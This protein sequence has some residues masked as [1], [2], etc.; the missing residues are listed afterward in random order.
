MRR[1]TQERVA[2]SKGDHAE[3]RRDAREV[4]V[5][6][7]VVLRVELVDGD[8]V[9]IF[10]HQLDALRRR[11]K[12]FVDLPI[13]GEVVRLGQAHV[14]LTNPQVRGDGRWQCDAGRRNTGLSTNLR[15]AG[16]RST[17]P[18]GTG[19]HDGR[20]VLASGSLS[21]QATMVTCGNM[22]LRPYHAIA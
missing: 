10:G 8:H 22:L 13:A 3:V 9:D 15:M 4:H 12:E 2:A 20:E 11:S 6:L 17:G 1:A 5:E 14:P 18:R 21:E 7:A 16:H 19:C